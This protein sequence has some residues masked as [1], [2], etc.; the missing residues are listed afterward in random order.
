MFPTTTKSITKLQGAV[1]IPIDVVQQASMNEEG[2]RYIKRRTTHDA[3][4][5]PPS[6]KSINHRMFHDLPEPCFY[7]YC[8]L[9]LLHSIHS[10]KIQHR[11]VI[12]LLIKY[13]IDA[14]YRRLHVVAKMAALAIT[15]LQNMA[16]I[17][18]IIILLK[19]LLVHS[20]SISS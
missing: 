7:R 5:P 3:S 11:A 16:Y 18:L 1:V 2:E 15:I 17:L 10:I 4:F 12:I 6:G 14:V 20:S 8:L 19:F 13:D 9:R